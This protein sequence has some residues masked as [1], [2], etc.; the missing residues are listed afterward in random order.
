MK[1]TTIELDKKYEV[2]ELTL[3]KYPKLFKKVQAISDEVG[4]DFKELENESIV[5]ALPKLLEEAWDEVIDLI[6]FASGVPIE[7]LNEK[8]GMGGLIQLWDAILEV[9]DI[10]LLKKR[11]APLFKKT[12]SLT[13]PTNLQKSTDGAQK[14]SEVKSPKAKQ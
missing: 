3:G 8:T 13:S 5:S 1:T 10:D 11:L 9:N 12:G 14:K 4:D 6:S 7:T 2:K